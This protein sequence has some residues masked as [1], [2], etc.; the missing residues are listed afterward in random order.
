MRVC[1]FG[2]YIHSHLYLEPSLV[3]MQPLH[4]GQARR[5]RVLTSPF[6]FEQVDNMEP[7]ARRE[8]LVI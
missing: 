2:R 3:K 7:A 8:G 1:P 4:V 5:M 6:T